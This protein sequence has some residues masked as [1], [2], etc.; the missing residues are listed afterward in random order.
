MSRTTC[1]AEL[2][3]DLAQGKRALRAAFRQSPAQPMEAGATIIAPEDPSG[4]VYWLGGGWAYR[5]R[6]W[7]GGRRAIIDIY[8]PGDVIGLEAALASRPSDTVV[9]LTPLT[10]QAIET[11]LAMPRLFGQRTVALFAYWLLCEQ[12]RRVDRL[13][14]T[15]A[16]FDAEG[17]LAVML[18]DFYERLRRRELITALS[19]TMPLTQ[20]QIG[21]HLGLTLVH[22]NRVL[23]SLREQRVVDVDRH[24]VLVRDL[25]RLQSLAGREIK[26]PVAARAV[27]PS[28]VDLPAAP[29]PIAAGPPPAASSASELGLDPQVA[30]ME[31][32]PRRK[33]L[34]DAAPVA[35]LPIGF[36]A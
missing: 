4:A 2:Y 8:L 12:Q 30:D 33:N 11:R 7:P 14:A 36:V 1:R 9:A 17:R 19:Y 26:M 29:A 18:L 25:A 21:D 35:D 5:A 6:G 15:I 13:A 31:A 32:V 23:R 27:A 10:L 34:G 28:R 16:R 20:Q 3:E 22:V 24:V